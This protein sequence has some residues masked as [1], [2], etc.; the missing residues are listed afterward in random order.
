MKFYRCPGPVK[1]VSFDLDDTLYDNA[2]VIGAAEVWFANL[3]TERYQLPDHCREVAFWKVEKNKTQERMPELKNEVTMLR[4]Q[5]LVDTFENLH[6][7]LKGGLEEGL[8]LTAE[9]V[10]ERSKVTVPQSSLELISYLRQFVPVAAVSNGNIDLNI[11]GLEGCFDFEL[12][13]AM[14]DGCRRKPH[15]DLYLRLAEHYQVRPCEILHIGDESGTD[16]LG[17]NRAGA[18]A[19]WLKGG[20]AGRCSLSLVPGSLPTVELHNLQELRA[21]FKA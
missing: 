7:P 9:F 2:P 19:A 5:G 10:A 6:C 14:H 8:A 20:I 11:A 17:A 21:F 13:P 4:A 3:L 12:R 18:Q 16:L 1:V 15:A